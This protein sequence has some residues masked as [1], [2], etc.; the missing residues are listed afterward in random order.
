[1]AKVRVLF[2]IGVLGLAGALLGACGGGGGG[3]AVTRADSAG[4]EIVTAGPNDVVLDWRLEPRF[5]LGG[6]A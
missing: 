3:A 6:E 4:V 5:T 1:M 2:V